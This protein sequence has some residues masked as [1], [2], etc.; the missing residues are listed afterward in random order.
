MRSAIGSCLESRQQRAERRACEDAGPALGAPR[1][2]GSW[3]SS[4]S[5]QHCRRAQAW[6]QRGQ[7]Q[8]SGQQ[9]GEAAEPETLPA[10]PTPQTRTSSSCCSSLA[11]SGLSRGHAREM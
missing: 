6:A 4:S 9:A 7:S 10:H 2:G 11:S 1:S 8:A 3:L 5:R